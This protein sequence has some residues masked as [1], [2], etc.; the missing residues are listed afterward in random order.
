MD[1]RRNLTKTKIMKS[2]DVKLDIYKKIKKSQAGKL[3]S[4]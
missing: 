4:A 3:A 2:E 1:S